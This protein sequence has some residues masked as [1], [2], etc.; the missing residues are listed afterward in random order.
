MD[1]S[2]PA[3]TEGDSTDTWWAAVIAKA[4]ISCCH[5]PLVESSLNNMA[6]ALPKLRSDKPLTVHLAQFKFSVLPVF[7][8]VLV[9][10]TPTSGGHATSSDL[11][12]VLGLNKLLQVSLD[13]PNVNLKLQ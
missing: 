1:D 11:L 5:R 10:M 9:T 3:V 8:Y 6:H 7:R 13:G 4:A 12:E 2:L